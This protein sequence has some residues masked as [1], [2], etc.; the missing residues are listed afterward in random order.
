MVGLIECLR[1]DAAPKAKMIIRVI[2]EERHPVLAFF[3]QI[4]RGV[5]AMSFADQFP[6]LIIRPVLA[7]QCRSGE[8]RRLISNATEP[9]LLG[10]AVAVN[11]N[12][13]GHRV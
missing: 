7:V 2:I 4:P 9:N 11:P 10:F 12:P 8:S 6:V 5:D 3:S 1:C 13:T